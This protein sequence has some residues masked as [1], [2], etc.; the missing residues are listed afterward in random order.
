MGGP[1]PLP[2]LMRPEEVITLKEA[3]YRTGRS[4]KTIARWCR[5]DGIG[6]RAEPGSAWE[7]SALA[8][9]AKRYGDGEAIEA[10]RQGRFAAPAV[11]RY[12][13]LLGLL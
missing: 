6:R 9:E 1:R 13:E 4:A 11:L 10:L 2:V 8:L 5:E 12:S 7:V 3:V